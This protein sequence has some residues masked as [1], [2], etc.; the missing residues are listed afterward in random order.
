MI[1]GWFYLLVWDGEVVKKLLEL[2]K[3]N[4]FIFDFND[5]LLGVIIGVM[6]LLKIFLLLKDK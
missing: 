1:V 5:C 3:G 2:G 4:I 6:E